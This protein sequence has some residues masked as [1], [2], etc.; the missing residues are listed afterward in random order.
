MNFY[1]T[2]GGQINNDQ[3]QTD[4]QYHLFDENN[5]KQERVIDLKQLYVYFMNHPLCKVQNFSYNLFKEYYTKWIE[6]Q[7]K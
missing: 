4:Q 6:E 5:N 7:Y 3:F 1:Y 2:N